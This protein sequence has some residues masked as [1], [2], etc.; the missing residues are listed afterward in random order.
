MD[1][2]EAQFR[3]DGSDYEKLPALRKVFRQ[4]R[5]AGLVAVFGESDDLLEFRGAIDED[6]GARRGT[7]AYVTRQGLFRAECVDTRCPYHLKAKREATPIKALWGEGG[8]YQWRIETEIPHL[9]FI[10][11]EF[12]K[13]YCRGV[14]FA[15]ADVPT[16]ELADASAEDVQTLRAFV[17]EA[18][19]RDKPIA[20]ALLRV[21][22][23]LAR[24]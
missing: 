24:A 22:P 12:G 9:S 6:L 4:M 15:L 21:L 1:L 10:L 13:P 20:E 7:T 8:T 23:S 14:I 2:K 11:W 16:S 19:S 17:E 5:D 3:L 18:N